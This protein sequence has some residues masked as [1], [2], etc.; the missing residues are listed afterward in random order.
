MGTGLLKNENQGDEAGERAGVKVV[1]TSISSACMEVALGIEMSSLVRI[2]PFLVFR[3]VTIR[4]GASFH[5]LTFLYFLFIA[6]QTGITFLVTDIELDE[7]ESA[8]SDASWTGS[9]FVLFLSSQQRRWLVQVA[10]LR[11]GSSSLHS[12]ENYILKSERTRSSESH[13]FLV[14]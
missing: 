5:S 2:L 14:G 1:R 8:P 11:S 12:E 9:L 3:T 7:K 6:F 4:N 13:E 10:S